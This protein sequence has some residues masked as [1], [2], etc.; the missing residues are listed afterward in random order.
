MKVLPYLS[1]RTQINSPLHRN[2]TQSQLNSTA[3]PIERSATTESSSDLR[4]LFLVRRSSAVALPNE[5]CIQI[6]K[7]HELSTRICA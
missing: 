3:V 1:E 5:M 7:L 6:H 4:V 2:A